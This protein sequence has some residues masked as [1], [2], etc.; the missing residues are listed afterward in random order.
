MA[1]VAIMSTNEPRNP[2]KSVPDIKLT[3][4]VRDPLASTTE[5]DIQR[6][7]GEGMLPPP[8]KRTR[9]RK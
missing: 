8:L 5:E 1:Y 9:K 7:E 2:L 3:D 6:A 4:P